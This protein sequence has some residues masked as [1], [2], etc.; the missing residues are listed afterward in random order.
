M[1]KDIKIS[2]KEAFQ[3]ISS[4]YWIWAINLYKE[5]FNPEKPMKKSQFSSIVERLRIKW[6]IN[7]N[8][9]IKKSN[10][11]LTKNELKN[12][13]Q[14]LEEKNISKH[15][16]QI[17]NETISKEQAAFILWKIIENKLEKYDVRI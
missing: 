11:N 16:S 7:S 14:S 3:A 1:P 15:I 10:R 17:S 6:L 9:E 8:Y 2:N 5:N 12:I 4:L 13:I